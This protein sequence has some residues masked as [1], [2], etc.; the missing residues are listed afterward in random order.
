MC[1]IAA[2]AAGSRAP[3]EERPTP[4]C[5]GHGKQ[6]KHYLVDVY[7][8]ICE[9]ICAKILSVSISVFIADYRFSIQS[10]N[11]TLMEKFVLGGKV[12]YLAS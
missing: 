10:D 1:V 7:P 4:T 12:A 8:A 3:P 9:V 11:A 5:S 2:A 6:N